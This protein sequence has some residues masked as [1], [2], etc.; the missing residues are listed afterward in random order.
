MINL[1]RCLILKT[2]YSCL[3]TNCSFCYFPDSF[4]SANFANCISPSPQIPSCLGLFLGLLFLQIRV[5][6]GDLSSSVVSIVFSMHMKILKYGCKF[7]NTLTLSK[8]L[9][10]NDLR[11]AKEILSSLIFTGYHFQG[12]KAELLSKFIFLCNFQVTVS[13]IYSHSKPHQNMVA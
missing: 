1:D 12:P 4:F 5:T 6:L 3:L 8:Y 13:V 2:L 11:S 7:F 9:D 10:P